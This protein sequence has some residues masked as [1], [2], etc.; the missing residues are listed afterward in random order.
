MSVKSILDNLK[1]TPPRELNDHILLVDS[2][3]TLIRSFTLIKAINSQGH[4]VGG[5]VGFLRSIGFLARTQD[6]S[7]M[8]CVFDGKGGS[9]NRKNI[10]SNYKAQR[11]GRIT[12]WGLYDSKEEESESLTAQLERLL[13]YLS[14]LPLHT[15]ML[16]KL[17]ADDVI[18]FIAKM[19]SNRGKKV[20]IVST[21][22]DFLQLIDENISVYSPIKK[23]T[24][25]QYNVR[26][27]IGVHPTNYNVLKALI[28]DNS[29]NLPGVR[30]VGV[31]TLVKEFPSLVTEANTPLEYVYEVA[32]KNID[33]KKI[34]AKILHEWD[35]VEK[36]FKLMDLHQELLD[37]SEKDHIFD[38]LS[39]PVPELRVGSFMSLLDMD[40]IDGITKNTDGWMENFR[41]L[42]LYK[43]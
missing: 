35:I 33:G 42:T 23:E 28:G 11:T 1:E 24:I 30:G 14:C 10:D 25:T 41:G 6:P 7:R 22:K 31:K 9:Q 8:I 19:A 18:A 26:E 20:T 13:D 15:L 40:K 4:H 36:N 16:E 17:E 27:K 38:V 43:R 5:L 32:E 37:T 29:D 21:D 2:L 12:N 34:F 3:N 39:S